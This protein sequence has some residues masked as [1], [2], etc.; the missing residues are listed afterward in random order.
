MNVLSGDIDRAAW[1]KLVADSATGTWFQTPAAYDF[2]A[3][4]QDLFDAFA[5][6]I[7]DETGHL[8][9]VCVGY[10]TK[11]ANAM[12]QYFTRR[13]II[14]GGP[15]LAND[16]TTEEVQA[17]MTAVRTQL[18]SRAI[19]I[20]TRNFNDYS[21]WR[22]AFENAGFT[23][24]PHLNFHV[25]TSSME[26]VTGRLSKNRKRDISTTIREGVRIVSSP[27]AEQVKQFYRILQRLYATKVKT[28]LFPLSFFMAL[29]EHPDGRLLLTEY[30][31]EIIGGTAC[32]V[33]S[34][35]C[36]YE[37]FVCGQDG[38]YPHVFPSS[39][40]TYA[41]IQ[42][43]AE[44]GCPRFDMMGAGTPN[45]AYG[46]RDFKARFGGQEVEYGRWLCVNEPALYTIGELGVKMLRR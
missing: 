45:E 8:R 18:Q 30:K 42:Y 16:C 2:F 37:W 25:D 40:A 35:R 27:S 26:T 36:V 24:Q 32:M 17:L 22:D 14:I 23:Y 34:G 28:P 31:G 5:V 13:A 10:V 3:S 11:E 46:V 39:Y 9:G 29:N 15:C 43:A 21:P 1:S 7:E 12:K 41:A 19:Y 33:L 38:V 4:Q 6:G 20:E 44:N